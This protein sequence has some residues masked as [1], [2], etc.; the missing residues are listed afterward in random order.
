M[1]IIHHGNLYIWYG[2]LQEF[3]PEYENIS[4][5][6]ERV[7]AYLDANDVAPAIRVSVV[8]SVIGP[9]TYSILRSL[10]APETPQ[11]KSLTRLLKNTTTQS[12][13]LLHNAIISIRN[14]SPTEN[15]ADYVAE[16]RRLA[17]SCE[18]GAFLDEA[19]RD[20]FICGLRSDSARCKL[21]T[22]PN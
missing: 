4:T 20:R 22:E 10:M 13:S 9:S 2:T 18:F 12:Q 19:L 17:A 11:T 14:Q 1:W 21:L 5:Y 8:L 15:I 3:K 7:K 16:L 6:L